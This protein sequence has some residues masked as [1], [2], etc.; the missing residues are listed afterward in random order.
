VKE[1]YDPVLNFSHCPIMHPVLF[2]DDAS[3]TMNW[4]LAGTGS[5]YSMTYVTTAALVGTNG[6]QFQTRTSGVTIEDYISATKYLW[7]PPSELLRLQLC[8]MNYFGSYFAHFEIF[9]HWYDGTNQ[10]LAGLRVDGTNGV[11][12]YWNGV[13]WTALSGVIWIGTQYY[14]TYIDWSINL[15]TLLHD[16]L[17]F[18]NHAVDMSAIP[19]PTAGSATGPHLRL[20]LQSTIKGGALEP[21][22]LDQIL[23]TAENP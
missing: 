8:I 22:Y 2:W 5:G 1:G 4:V 10:H 11:V 7:L 16:R 14:W 17:I 13:S 20:K 18:A 19:I 3:G 9:L 23:L 15:R 21:L 6:I 12:S